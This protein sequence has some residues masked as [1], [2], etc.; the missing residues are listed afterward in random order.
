MHSGDAQMSASIVQILEGV[1]GAA[2]RR[3]VALSAAGSGLPSNGIRRNLPA[4][5]LLELSDGSV[6]RL[7]ARG[8]ALTPD[9][10]GDLAEA[11]LR[12]RAG[13]VTLHAPL[14]D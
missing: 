12:V 6:H 14:N 11:V 7:N 10:I 4:S 2:W 8:A 5:A 3:A 13:M 1:A 9:L